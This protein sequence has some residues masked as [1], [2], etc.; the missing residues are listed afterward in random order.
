MNSLPQIV[1]IS[2]LNRLAR[3]ALEREI[4]LLW[5]AGE[6]S[7]L[8]RAA[9]GRVYFNLKD[10]GAQ[11]RCVIFRARAGLVPW[12]LA[13]GQQVEARALV[14]LYEPRGEFQLNIESMRRAGLAKL[15]EAFSRL[16]AELEGEGLFAPERK[17]ALPRYPRAIGIVSSLQAAALHDVLTALSRRAPNVPVFIYPTAVQGESAPAMICSALDAANQHAQCELLLVVRG[18]GSI[19]DLWAFNN[20]AVARAIVA[21]RLPVIVGV[22]HETDTTIADFVADQRAATPTAA[23]EL[24]SEAWFSAARQ[25]AELHSAMRAT[26]ERRLNTMRQRVDEASRRLLH[27]ATRLQRVHNQL[28]MLRQRMIAAGRRRLTA[29]QARLACASTALTHLNPEAILQRG[30][31]IVV[32]SPSGKVVTAAE[33]ILPN[34]AVVL[35]FATGAADARIERTRK[36]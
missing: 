12:A 2:E 10:D 16:K 18:G 5:V 6:I 1:S 36:E 32:A 25:V 24:A 29:Q 22:G 35:R 11:A 34:D 13:N 26:M 27:P 21:S 23:A 20:E 17:R 8:T 9:S 15:Y 33:Q 19:E 31:S 30:Y 28:A 3:N 4:P 7:N 14:S